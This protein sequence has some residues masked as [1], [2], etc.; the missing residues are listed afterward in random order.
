MKIAYIAHP[1]GGD[2]EGNI[3][4]IKGIVYE[5]NFLET[6]VVPFVPYLADC[7]ALKDEVPDQRQRGIRNNYEIINRSFID[8]MR[9]YGDRISEGV[10][11]EIKHALILGIP[12]KPMTPETKKEFEALYKP[13]MK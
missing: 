1:I 3:E 2:V 7:L 11:Y 13:A 4:K 12:V 6:N 9:L 10:H 8:E 5:I